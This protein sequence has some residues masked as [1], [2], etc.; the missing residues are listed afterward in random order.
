M[1]MTKVLPTD[2]ISKIISLTSPRDACRSSSVSS[3]FKKAEESDDV[4]ERFLPPD[5]QNIILQYSSSSSLTDS[6][7]KR[8]IFFHLCD[9][10]FLLDNGQMRVGLEK[11]SGK[12]CITV[13]AKGLGII[14][15]DTLP[16]WDSI[17]VP[18]SRFPSVA[19]LNHVWWLDINGRISA[20]ILSQRTNYAAFFIFKL[21]TEHCFTHRY[22]EMSVNK[23]ESG[24]NG[25]HRRAI[26][27]ASRNGK[28]KERERERGAREREDGWM[29]IEMGEFFIGENGDDDE[30]FVDCRLWETNGYIKGG[31]LVEGIEFRPKSSG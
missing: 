27:E 22:V 3:V 18:Q 23:E 19:R 12:K 15:G 13:G 2:C 26:L 24:G 20:N 4:W 11:E 7:T 10:P 8:Q 17:S 25:S 21:E 5:Y 29:E 6:L 28:K 31:L 16:Y 30:G 1:D 14:W 9:H